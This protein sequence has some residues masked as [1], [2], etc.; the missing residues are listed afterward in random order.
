MEQPISFFN[1]SLK[2]IL[3]AEGDAF[4]RARIKILFT[5]LVLA[6]LKAATAVTIAIQNQQSFN[7]ARSVALFTIILL[8]IKLLLAQ[9]IHV[10]A[11]THIMVLL[12][13][14]LIWTNVLIA[15][16]LV[17][18][19]TVQFIIII[20]LSSFYLLDRKFAVI[21]SIGSILPSLFLP[22][23]SGHT[24]L[25]DMSGRLASPGYE[26]IVA[27]NFLTIIII[28]YF[29]QQAYVATIAEKESLNTKLHI[30]VK[31]A[32]HATESKSDFLSTMSHELRTPLN[33]VI[34]ISELLLNDSYNKEQEEN[35]R[36]LRFSALNLHALINDI[37][38]YN[39][40]G[41]EMLRL[42][43]IPVNISELIQDVSSG[44]AFQAKQKNIDFIIDIDNA[45]LNHVVITDP[46][47]ITQIIYNLSGNAI[48][49]TEQGF[50]SISLKV[51]RSDTSTITI[52]FSVVDTGIGIS[53]DK[54]AAIFE[55]FTQASSSTTRNFGGTGLGL[56]IVKRLLILFE[57]SIDLKS[58]P[59]EG[60]T[61]S[62]DI[63]FKSE[64]KAAPILAT[65]YE[66]IYDLSNLNVLIA[67]DNPVN[68][69]LM[70]KVFAKWN[71]QPEF[72]TNG[73]EAIDK[74]IQNHYHVILMD[75]HM[76]VLNGYEASKAIRDLPDPIK[77]E[78][79]IIA[80]TASVSANLD[81]KIL[82][83]GMNDYVLKP[84][85]LT[86]L[87]QKLIAHTIATDKNLSA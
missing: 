74:V 27:L 29:F 85:K 53:A 20:I 38:D 21:Y 16:K 2:K 59:G 80:L 9:K 15:V 84:F 58:A 49:F 33:S 76:P 54:Q 22:F 66:A 41:S 17:N 34:G 32:N 44:L 40:L 30:A 48:K 50:V 43:N 23:V 77:S 63:I 24:E 57:S 14:F 61:F 73:Q 75:L 62:F 8:L 19:A 87:Y 52:R 12:A 51:L 26:I 35:L 18:V 55:P 67:E 39:K 78:L 31:E 1:W 36:I 7:I 60:S 82:D 46:T 47:R 10:K 37:L 64:S 28:H 71:N 45:I 69:L 81:E 68:R 83:A 6:I 70:T 42:E 25:T 5:I 11:L 86:E 4:N 65:D 56:A 79:K 13:L 3:R 72:A